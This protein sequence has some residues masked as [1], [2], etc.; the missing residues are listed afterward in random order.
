M[1]TKNLFIALLCTL[2]LLV[3]GADQNLVN[4]TH[5]PVHI[6]SENN[7]ALAWGYLSSADTR[8]SVVNPTTN[9]LEGIRVVDG[10]HGGPTVSFQDL[11][12]PKKY[13][14]PDAKNGGN[15]R[16]MRMVTR[17]EMPEYSNETVAQWNLTASFFETVALDGGEG[18]SY[19]SAANFDNWILHDADKRLV[20]SPYFDSPV[21]AKRASWMPHFV[22][23][24]A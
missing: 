18:L 8:M 20:F 5:K 16:Y 10:L 19:E 4:W 21:L 3:S 22:P 9:T 14:I 2:I 7:V 23:P 1:A 17:P 24:Q 13:L 12:D 11:N 6:Y 15:P